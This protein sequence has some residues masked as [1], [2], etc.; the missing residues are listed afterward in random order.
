MR[1]TKINKR[2]ITVLFLFIFLPVSYLSA[3]SWSAEDIEKID[4]NEKISVVKKTNIDAET[5]I[6]LTDKSG[7]E[8][9][10]ASTIDYDSMAVRNILKLKNDFF[11]WPELEISK[12][13]FIVSDNAIDISVIPIKLLCKGTNVI[14]YLPAGMFFTYTDS[15]Q[16]NFRMTKNNLFVRIKGF[17]INKDHLFNRIK[18]ALDNPSAYI[19][20]RD[21]EFF[22]AKLEQLQNDLD[23]FRYENSTLRLAVIA[24]II[25]ENITQAIVDKVVKMKKDN[26]RLTSRQI[27]DKLD[28][29]KIDIS[30]GDVEVI[31]AVYFNEFPD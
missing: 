6:I 8:F 16:Y 4:E 28:Q 2:Y 31:I 20:K 23:R 10:V 19:K 26:S 22:L 17:F 5:I 14:S 21:P 9:E 15:L 24:L 13:K 30:K 27:S 18:E 29:Q 3:F 7:K 11:S 25:D 12:I 1:S